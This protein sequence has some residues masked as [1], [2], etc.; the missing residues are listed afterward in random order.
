MSTPVVDAPSFWA[1]TKKALAGGIAGLAT[2]GVGSAITAALSDG[3]ITGD[4]VWS[5]IGLAV[6]GFLVGFGA[7][8]AAP[9]NA[10]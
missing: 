6:G 2:G 5:I 1:R 4:E 3:A 10:N 7:V 8:Y 9:A